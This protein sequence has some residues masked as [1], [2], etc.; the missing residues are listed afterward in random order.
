MLLFPS[1]P[2][3]SREATLQKG[4]EEMEVRKTGTQSTLCSGLQMQQSTRSKLTS[5]D[6]KAIA[7]QTYRHLGCELCRQIHQEEV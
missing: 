3:I 6:S 5:G 4:L 7:S 2:Q 1:L